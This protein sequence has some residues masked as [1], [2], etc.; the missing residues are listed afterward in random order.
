MDDFQ[1]E[2]LTQLG[3]IKKELATNTQATLDLAG[4]SGR[5]TALEKAQ[6]WHDR[7]QWIHTVVVLPILTLGHAA[8]RKFGI[9]V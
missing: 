7:K 1:L 2:V 4:P 9:D 8:L 3:D 5:V 6:Q